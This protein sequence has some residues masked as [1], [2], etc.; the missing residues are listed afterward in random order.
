MECL[1]CS[2][3][4]LLRSAQAGRQEMSPRFTDLPT[5]GEV[6]WAERS[7][8]CP[9]GETNAWGKRL[10]VLEPEGCSDLP[11]RLS[12]PGTSILGFCHPGSCLGPS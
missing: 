9:G 8:Y 4:L 1:T 7:Q 12:Q 11:L 2:A 5:V 6:G 3:H 10:L